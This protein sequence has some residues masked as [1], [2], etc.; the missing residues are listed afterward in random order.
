MPFVTGGDLVF[1]FDSGGLLNVI[2][3]VSNGT[4]YLER[5]DGGVSPWRLDLRDRAGQTRSVTALDA[6]TCQIESA[7]EGL[8]F[9]WGAIRNAPDLV[10]HA[11]LTREREESGALGGDGLAWQLAVEGLHPDAALWQADFPV[12]EGIGP[13]GRGDH[14][15]LLLPKAGGHV[16]SNAAEARLSEFDD[17]AASFSYP[18]DLTMQFVAYYR[19]GGDGLLVMTRDP[20]GWYKRFALERIR[21][22]AWT[23]AVEHFPAG[24]PFPGGNLRQDDRRFSPPYPVIL[25][26]FD[27]DWM[28]AAAR[29]RT[30]AIRQPWCSRGPLHAR[31][32]LPSWLL[33]NGLWVWNRGPSG[34]VLPGARRIQE[35]V[36][37]PVALDWY[38][39]HHTPYDTHFPDYL[40]PRE[41]AEAFR[42]AVDALHYAGLRAIAYVNGRLWGTGAPSWRAKHAERA[43]C[44]RERGDIYREAYNIFDPNRAEVTP[45]CPATAL[46]QTTVR[47]VVSEL[48][49]RYQL[50]GVY[51]DQ[52]GHTQPE[53]CYA[54]QH[55]H[56]A[57]GGNHWCNGYRTLMQ[58]MR[59]AAQAHR[60]PNGELRQA[61]LPTEGSCEAYLDL[62]DAFLVLDNSFERM[63]FYDKLDLNWES[64]PLFAAVYHDY[65]LHFGSYASLAPPPYDDLWPQ[66]PV[67]VRS[68]RFR[69]RD[70]ADAFY[71]E[72][73]RAFVAG[74]Q[75]MVSNVYT[76]ELE[77]PSLQEHWRFLRELVHT[78]LH[79]SP[80]LVYGAW[81]RPPRLVVPETPVDFLVRGIYTLPEKEHV[82]QRRLPAVLASLWAAPDGRQGLALA[83]ISRNSQDIAWRSE[84]VLA[85][86]QTYLIDERG[87]SRLGRVGD[88]G[89]VFEGAIPARSVRVIE[90]AS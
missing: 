56:P 26:A 15:R 46:W 60:S 80:F 69:E 64:V 58:D 13:M 83:N 40:P 47:D 66:P 18:C 70:F 37:A 42:Q 36:Q 41:G 82:I 62:F 45:M 33:G 32:D 20:D 84:G 7:G 88:D 78:R 19:E 67:P 49:D 65:A 57:G 61:I 1:A 10:V 59:Q 74:A 11:S 52:I 39:W 75:P 3:R 79:A 22:L 38:W 25:C 90:K 72:L 85:G 55:G 8:R 12:L 54:P 43:A 35:M 6:C 2:R 44:T 27:G 50:D 71:A 87:R 5:Q 29:Y 14:E 34:R 63:G 48:L 53:M 28:D 31:Q 4:A 73:G 17:G 9:E 81:L 30:W 68:E 76:S 51:L 16:V 86:Q 24:M 77:D 21:G 89:L 23:L